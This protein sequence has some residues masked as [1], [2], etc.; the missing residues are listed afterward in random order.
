MLS[1]RYC[2]SEEF[3]PECEGDSGKGRFVAFAVAI[4]HEQT[5]NRVDEGV[6]GR[7]REHKDV[8]VD[9]L[10][11]GVVYNQNTHL[12]RTIMTHMSSVK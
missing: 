5:R 10:P 11:F 3:P 6:G 2:S 7:Q 12:Q 8:K 1:R 9:I 4:T